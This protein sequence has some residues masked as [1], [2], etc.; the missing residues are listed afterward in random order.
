MSKRATAEAEESGEIAG[1]DCESEYEECPRVKRAKRDECPDA[2]RD[3]SES[4]DEERPRA[5]LNIE[6]TE[7][8]MIMNITSDSNAERFESSPILTPN[9]LTC[10]LR[11]E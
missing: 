11:E 7:M 9:S 10:V 1:S 2:S 5:K 3:E 8:R 4:D 6:S